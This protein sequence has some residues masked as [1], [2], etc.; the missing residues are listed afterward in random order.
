VQSARIGNIRILSDLCGSFAYSEVKSVLE[1]LIASSNHRGRR[2]G[3]EDKGFVSTRHKQSSEST[4]KPV[5]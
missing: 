1:T 5:P 4:P 2:E 3:T